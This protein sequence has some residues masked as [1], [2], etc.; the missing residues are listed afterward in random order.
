[1]TFIFGPTFN[2]FAVI[3]VSTSNVPMTFERMRRTKLPKEL[4]LR[5]KGKKLCLQAGMFH[6]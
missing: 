1:M 5:E 2:G 3:V 6:R 4:G